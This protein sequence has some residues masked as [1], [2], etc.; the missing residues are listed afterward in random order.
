VSDSVAAAAAGRPAY[1]ASRRDR[2]QMAGGVC[3]SAA[4]Y[5]TASRVP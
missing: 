3:S 5:G 2:Y 4:T 1:Q